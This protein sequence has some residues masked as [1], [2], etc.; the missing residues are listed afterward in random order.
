MLAWVSSTQGV[1][2]SPLHASWSTSLD[3]RGAEALVVSSTSATFEPVQVGMPWLQAPYEWWCRCND[4]FAKETAGGGVVMQTGVA[5]RRVDELAE[6]SKHLSLELRWHDQLLAG[7]SGAVPT[8]VSPK[9][10]ELAP[11]GYYAGELPYRR[12]GFDPACGQPDSF[13]AKGGGW[14]RDTYISKRCG[15]NPRQRAL[16]FV[17]AA[18]QP[19][20]ASTAVVHESSPS[21]GGLGLSAHLARVLGP[22]RYKPTQYHPTVPCGEALPEMPGNVA[23]D[24]E[25]QSCISDGSFDL[26]ITQDVFEHVFDAASAFAE[27]ERTLK[28]GGMHMQAMWGSNLELAEGRPFY[29][30]RVRAPH[31]SSFTVPVTAKMNATFEA[32][33]RASDGSVIMHAPPEIHGN[34]MSNDGSLVTHQWGFDMID[35]IRAHAR[36]T[37]AGLMRCSPASRESIR[38]GP[39]H[40]ST[41][42]FLSIRHGDASGLPRER[43]PRRGARRVP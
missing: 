28:P 40:F 22:S 20:L 34:P 3:G 10:Y 7:G 4:T 23:L 11:Q 25:N 29:Y 15:T 39:V 27:I 32:A 33:T 5:P 8:W 14:F 18:L 42:G 35:F 17:L 12:E 30:S 26:V 2:R 1:P 41:L 38:A 24:L 6:L 43:A 21:R 37:R 9:E 19:E 13:V 16:A 31:R 36:G